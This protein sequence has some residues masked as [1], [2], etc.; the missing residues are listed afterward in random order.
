MCVYVS[1]CTH[2]CQGMDTLV[3]GFEEEFPGDGVTGSCE[4]D[5]GG[6]TKPGSFVRASSVLS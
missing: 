6:K 4:L 2:L 5:M 1:M 3:Q